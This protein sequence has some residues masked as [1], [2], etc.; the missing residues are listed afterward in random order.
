MLNIIDRRYQRNCQGWS[1]RELLQVGGLSLA[2]LGLGDLLRGEAEAAADSS[3]LPAPRAHSVIYL[4]QSG[5]PAQHE[6]WDLK[7]DAPTGIRG[8]FA[9]IDTVTPGMQ[10]CEHLPELARRSDKLA[11]QEMKKPHKQGLKCKNPGRFAAIRAR[12]K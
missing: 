11:N 5:G 8:E 4:F 3:N 7:P 1:R 10:I 6:T 9:P 2:G 12:I